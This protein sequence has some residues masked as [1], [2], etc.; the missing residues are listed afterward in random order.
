MQILSLTQTY[1]N[2]ESGDQIS[3]LLQALRVSL[4]T[5]LI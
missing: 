2:S 4:S 1:R 3:E 5:L